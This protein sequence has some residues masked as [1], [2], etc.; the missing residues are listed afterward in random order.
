MPSTDRQRAPWGPR[1]TLCAVVLADGPLSGCAD[2]DVGDFFAGLVE[3]LAR[4][5]C[6]SAHNCDNLNAEGEPFAP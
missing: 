1:R 3:N 4:N 2:R 6:E 5:A